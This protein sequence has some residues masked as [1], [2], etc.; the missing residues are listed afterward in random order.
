ME[1]L[2]VI[3]SGI[4][5]VYQTDTGERIVYG[6]ELHAVLEVKSKFADWVKNRLN[7]CDATENKDFESFSKILE[8][9]GRP[10]TEYIIKLETAKEMAM[11]ERNDKGKQVR[12]YFIQVEE[13]YKEVVQDRITHN[14]KTLTV[15]SRDICKMLGKTLA[16]HGVIMREMRECIVELEEMGFNRLDFFMDSIYLGGG[17]GK[18]QYPQFLCTERGCEYFSGRLEPTERKIFIS[19][20]KDRFRRLQGVLDDKPVRD[21]VQ[22]NTR[23]ERETVFRLYQN[24]Q[25]GI[26]VLDDEVYNLT[27]E[28]MN[29]ISNMVPCLD[30]NGVRQIKTVIQ[31]YLENSRKGGKLEKIEEYHCL[32]GEIT[33]IPTLPEVATSGKVRRLKVDESRSLDEVV[34][35]TIPDAQTRYRMSRRNILKIVDEIG[36][37]VSPGG[38]GKAMLLDRKKLDE[39]FNSISS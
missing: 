12:R 3:E 24:N 32:N 21:V 4:V 13:K 17:G 31:T 39:Y 36:A 30:K 28:E 37:L 16:S 14:V 9:G 35:L 10:Q 7:D 5:P 1:K 18:E 25:W 26:L 22:L 15:T 20:F 27:P 33:E 19:E 23:S 2:K 11:L 6:T 8:K 34:N 38:R 29:F